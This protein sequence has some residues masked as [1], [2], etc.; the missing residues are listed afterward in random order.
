M[1][2]KLFLLM[3]VFSGFFLQSCDDDDNIK[4]DRQLEDL[5][6]EMYPSAS[7]V[8]WEMERGYYIADFWMNGYEAEACFDKQY[9][10]IMTEFDI[11]FNDLPEAVRNSY[12]S[13]EYSD[14]R[15]DDIDK[16]DYADSET[17]YLI[18]IEKG[19]RELNLVYAADG[20]LIKSY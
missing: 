18:E 1:K 8:K 17:E 7:G 3:C 16:F 10:W 13:S 14:W 4:V 11:H 12:S 9:K 6:N 2:T 15:I 19:N 5:F 20:S